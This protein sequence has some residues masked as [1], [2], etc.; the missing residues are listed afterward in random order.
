MTPDAITVV[1]TCRTGRAQHRRGPRARPLGCRADRPGGRRRDARHRRRPDQPRPRPPGGAA[2]ANSWFDPY[3]QHTSAPVDLA[4]HG[5][6]T[7]GLVV[8][9]ADGA[10]DRGGARGAPA[11]RRAI[12][13]DRG[14]TTATAMHQ[15]FQ[16]VLD[17]DHDPATDGRT[18]ASSTGPGRSAP[19]PRATWSS[20]RRAGPASRPGSCRCSRPATSGPPR[21]T[22][23]SPANYPESLSVGATATDGVV[24]GL[25]ERRGPD[26]RRAD[27]GSSRTSWPP[28]SRCSRRTC[29]AG[30]ST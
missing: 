15:A 17:P 6:A 4:G 10:R 9:G 16:W 28:A 8:G 3:G 26:L 18:P 19:G 29:S 30:T 11:S 20:A 24:L 1:P 14:A 7:A 27:T 12:F 21:R 13:D 22:S 5:T 2:A 25:L 23:A